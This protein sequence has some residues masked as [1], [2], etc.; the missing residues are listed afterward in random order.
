MHELQRIFVEEQPV[1]ITGAA[2]AGA[3]YSTRNWEGWPDENNQYAPPQPTL[4]NAL[5]VVLHL[6]PAA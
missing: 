3:E 5:D 6:R 1:L 4:I 2:N